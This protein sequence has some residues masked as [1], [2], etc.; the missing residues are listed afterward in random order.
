MQQLALDLGFLSA[1]GREDFILGDC[2][3]DAAA[4]ID[5]W[6]DWPGQFRVLNL[7][8]PPASGKSH[9]ASVWR[10]R[11]GAAV[12]EGLGAYDAG[13]AFDDHLVLDC[14]APGPQWNE[15]ALFHLVNAT[16]EAGRSLLLVSRE[17]VARMD[18]R[19]ADLGS[20]L[21]SAQMAGLD[22]PDDG[23]LK[24]VLGKH[25]E[26]RKLVIA[27]E[28]IDYMMVR[29]ERSFEA[30]RALATEMDRQ[31]LAQ[32][33]RLTLPLA[34]E[35]LAV[36]E[37]RQAG[38]AGDAGGTENAGGAEQARSVESA[39]EAGPAIPA[40]VPAGARH[41]DH[42]HGGTGGDL[43]ATANNNTMGGMDA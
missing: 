9:L 23:L 4:R 18:W 35:I 1:L 24:M 37:S 27:E 42:A 21:R 8:G 40:P 20:R 30:V 15:E 41:R 2:N 43:P 5:R 19:L 13:R 16:A 14:L 12:L 38:A 34:R 7:V 36:I 10:E 6:P 11:S 33:R 29:M 22:Q 32:H 17:P 25:F 26:D 39:G 28:V 3:R 31:S